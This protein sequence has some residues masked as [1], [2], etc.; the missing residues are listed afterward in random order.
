[1]RPSLSNP[2]RRIE[3][4]FL[5]ALA[6]LGG[7]LIATLLVAVVLGIANSNIFWGEANQIARIPIPGRQ[8][9][10]LPGG[11]TQATVAVALPGRGNETPELLVPPLELSVTPYGEAGKAEIREELGSSVNAND[12]YDDTQRA[13]WKID[14]PSAGTYLVSVKGD[15][16][17]YGVNAQLW[18][19]HEPGWLHGPTI[20]FVAMLIVALLAAIFAGVA[21][22]RRTGRGGSGDGAGQGWEVPGGTP[23]ADGETESF[24]SRIARVN[25]R[26]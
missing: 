14:A 1:M 5:R 3:S 10:E 18:L 6:Y 12:K 15:M 17:G 20:W 7:F 9:V 11:E 24:D 16:T 22:L 2:I 21:W 25:D 19:G 8:K 13:V 4:G 23:P 26:G